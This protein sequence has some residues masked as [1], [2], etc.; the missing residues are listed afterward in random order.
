MCCFSNADEL[1]QTCTDAPS[2]LHTPNIVESVESISFCEYAES[3]AI[4]TADLMLVL[5]VPNAETTKILPVQYSQYLQYFPPKTLCF[6][7]R[8]REHLCGLAASFFFF[9]GISGFLKGFVSLF[10]AISPPVRTALPHVGGSGGG[11]VTRKNKMQLSVRSTCFLFH[12]AVREWHLLFLP[13]ELV[14]SAAL[15][16]VLLTN[17]IKN[18]TNRDKN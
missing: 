4:L 17:T 8:Y 2:I 7:P 16:G 5:A 15:K 18:V 10:V 9:V 3:I 14:L 13:A 11:G 6:T 1:V 12:T